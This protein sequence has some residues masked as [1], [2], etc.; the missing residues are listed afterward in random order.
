[1]TDSVVDN[2]WMQHTKVGAW[3]DGPMDNFTIRNSRILDQTA[4]GVNFHYGV[5]NSTV[6]NTFVR[7]TGDDGLAMWAEN[8]PNVKQHVHLQHGRSL[9]ILANNIVTYGGK[10][11]T[12]SD[13][14]MADTVT[15]GGGMHIA[16]RYP[17]RQLRPGHGGLRHHHGRPQHPDPHRQLRLQLAASASARSGSAGSTSRSAA[18]RSTSPTPTSWTAPTRRSTGSRARPTGSTSTTSGSTARARTRCR[19]RRPAQVSFTNVVATHIAQSNPIHNCVGSGFQITQGA[20]NS[21]WYADPPACT[22]VWPDPVWTN[23]GVPGGAAA[24]RT[25]RPDRSHR[26]RRT[27]PG[28]GQPRPGPAGHRDQPRRRRT[29]PGN[30]VDG[31]AE[32]LLGEPQQ[33]LPAVGHR[34]PRRREGGEAAGAEASSG[35]RLGDPHPDASA[36]SGSTDNSAYS[37]LKASA[38]YTFDPST[39]NTATV[40]ADGDAGPLPAADVHREHRL[41]GGPALRAGGLHRADRAHD[42]GPGPHGRAR[43]CAGRVRA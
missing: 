16:N 3:M 30:A 43:R 26:T 2:V 23:G 7:N 5:T 22:R 11:I 28:D 10:D 8:V 31:N 27:R 18:P 38:G 41:A 29:A 35:R 6:T 34:G 33:R 4:D 21:G 32:Q 40:H 12:I 9:P 15:N 36:C 39:G 25:D 17:G 37:T 14:V 42:D 1:M 13:N 19:S 20:G 24:H